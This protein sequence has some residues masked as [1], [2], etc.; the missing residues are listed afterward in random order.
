[1][2]QLL[3]WFR[4][5][6]GQIADSICFEIIPG[7]GM[8]IIAGAPIKANEPIIR[9]PLSLCLSVSNITR[10]SLAPVFEACPDLV[11]YPA[12]VRESEACVPGGHRC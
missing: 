6:G 1:M 4:E 2:E 12:E 5:G 8:S 7:A 3:E 10:S 9:V 11:Q